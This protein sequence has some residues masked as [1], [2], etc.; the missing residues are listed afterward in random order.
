ME[1]HTLK[2]SLELD[3]TTYFETHLMIV[4]AILPKERRLSNKEIEVLARFM[5]MEGDLVKS[6]RFN[7]T[8]RRSVRDELNLSHQG[9]SNHITGIRDKGF[10]ITDPD[11]DKYEIIK[12]SLNVLS[13]TQRYA[14]QLK[15]KQN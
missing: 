2:K 10:I 12:P 1:I 14:L 6:N 3:K 11:N 7:S 5:S 13:F 4:N 8:A 9:L 15:L